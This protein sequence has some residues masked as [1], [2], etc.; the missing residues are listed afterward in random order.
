[1]LEWLVDIG[2]GFG[3][4][5]QLSVF[6]AA[7]LGVIIGVV[8]GVIPGLGPAVAISISIP[9]TYSLGAL[10]AISFMLGCYKGGTYGG[11]IS[12]ILLNTPG[13]PA[14]AATVL[15]GYPM[16]KQGKPGKALGIA[17][18]ASV[19]GD[20]FSIFI[21]CVMAELIA[22][23][24][25]KFGPAELFSLMLFALTIIAA[26]SSRS[27]LKGLLGGAL[28]LLAATVGM[29]SV[30]GLPRFTFDIMALDDGFT[31]IP[32]VIGMFA[33]TEVFNQVEQRVISKNTTLL[34]ISP[35]PGDR[36]VSFKDLKRCFPVFLQSSVLGVGIGA[37]PGTGS[38]TAAYLS[39]GLAQK[40]SKK[41][42]EF[43]HGAIEGLAAAESGNNAVCGGAL[44][45]MLT[46]GIPGDVV[47][48]ILMSALMVHG[49]HTGPLIFQ[50]HRAFV[51]SLFAMLLISIFMLYFVG[52]V[53]IIG[54]RG[55]AK[56]S[57]TVV[58]PIVLLL[59]AAGSY[60]TTYS[61]SDIWMMLAF[62][63]VG[64]LMLK[65]EIPLPPFVIAYVLG[66]MVEQSLRRAL[67]LSRGSAEI[68]FTRPI[69]VFFL[70]LALVSA[71]SI[72]RGA[73]KRMA[74]ERSMLQRVAANDEDPE[75][76]AN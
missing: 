17:L 27:L 35:D 20:A 54:C 67:M 51:F 4:V 74:K 18:Y 5:I 46:L 36:W 62:A 15:D 52:R 37:L 45:P 39:Y 3:S 26:L 23:V 47:T 63:V 64:Y 55:L 44:I 73:R 53:A 16:A 30:T 10:T 75:T 13:T 32:M 71:I 33:V 43:G 28:G 7:L 24:A 40:R 59:C 66:P 14:A 8:V 12:A 65:L 11:S 31:I 6:L 38:T 48:A 58:M 2:A 22:K 41:P 9:L 34:P 19:F 61:M 68:F 57:P 50:D 60:S 76:I 1:M 42:E 49:I 70:L 72:A 29:D 69:S 21:L 56:M 25:L